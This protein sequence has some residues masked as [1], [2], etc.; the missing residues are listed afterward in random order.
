[1][2]GKDK[3]TGHAMV[4]NTIRSSTS[5][6]MPNNAAFEGQLVQVIER[7]EAGD[8]LCVSRNGKAEMA[9][10]DASDIAMF[11]PMKKNHMNLIVPSN[12]SVM[13][14]MNWTAMTHEFPDVYTPAVLAFATRENRAPTYADFRAIHKMC[15]DPDKDVSAMW[16]FMVL[17]GEELRKAANSASNF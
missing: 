9:T 15:S 3:E 13:E 16:A 11:I 10:I 8:C 4:A 2:F 12:M 5:H 1:M 17:N 7:N 14:E 6:C